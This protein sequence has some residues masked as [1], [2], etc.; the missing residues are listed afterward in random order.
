MKKIL[1][2]IY[3]ILI[4]ILLKLVMTFS[5]NESFIVSYNNGKYE[6]LKA[7]SMLLLNISEPYVAHYNYGNVLY[8][9][10]DF[11]GAIDEYQRA[12]ELFPPKYKECDIR[13]N[14]ALAMLQ[15][16]DEVNDDKDKILDILHEAKE[17][18]IEDGCAHENDDNGHSEDAEKLKADIEKMEE[19]LKD[20]TTESE[21]EKEEEEET[22]EVDEKQKQ[23]E[24]IQNQATQERQQEMT[25]YNISSDT[26][27]YRY[28]GKKW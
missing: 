17:V 11:Q 28:R 21:E 2:I 19:Q 4:V 9:K 26:S 6:T 23:L 25:D 1:K 8:Q 5:I 16:I 3:A 22:E 15:E 13:I 12:L 20:S 18:L 27:Y 10:N 14:L 24:E 7:Q